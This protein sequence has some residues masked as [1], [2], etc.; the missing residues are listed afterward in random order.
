MLAG[1]LKLAAMVRWWVV[2]HHPLLAHSPH[3][4]LGGRLCVRGVRRGGGREAEVR[5]SR[6]ESVVLFELC[7][8]RIVVE[9]R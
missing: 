5:T 7:N 6:E 1:E 4:G 3:T 9:I 2:L 8:T